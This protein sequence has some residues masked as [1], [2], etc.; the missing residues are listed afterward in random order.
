MFCRET[1]GPSIC[2][3]INLTHATFLN[4][5]SDL[6]YPFMATVFPNGSGLFQPDNGP[7]LTVYIVRQWFQEHDEQ[8]TVLP[9]LPNCPDFN[10]IE[11]LWN[12]LEQQVRSTTAPPRNLQDLQDLL[13][14]SWC[15]IP[16]GTFK[17]LSAYRGSE[18]F[19]WHVE[20]QLHVKS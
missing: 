13:L 12:E 1:L 2:V 7:C 14:T 5:V 17:D 6:V 10:L 19:W 8:F 16:Q 3:H 11:H 4:I 15:Q 20:D 18:L 9:W